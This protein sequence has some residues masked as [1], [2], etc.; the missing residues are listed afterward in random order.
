MPISTEFGGLKD[1][2]YFVRHYYNTHSMVVLTNKGNVF[3]QG[4]NGSG[5][6]GLGDTVD[7]YQLV[8]NPYLGP[9]ATNNSITCEVAAV[10]TND[11]GGYQGMVTLTTSL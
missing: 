10:A 11:A 1:G 5:Q 2:E 4:E 3:V 9:D 7:R 6:L 8:K